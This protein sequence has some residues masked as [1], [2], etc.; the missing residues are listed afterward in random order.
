[1][2]NLSSALKWLIIKKEEKFLFFFSLFLFL[3]IYGG[4]FLRMG[5]S[6]DET[7]DAYGDATGTYVAAGRWG[8]AL[9]RT[10]MGKGCMPWAYGMVSACAISLA[11]IYQIRLFEISC[12]AIRYIY[13]MASLGCTQ[14]LYMLPYSF[15]ADCVAVSL[16][17]ATIACGILYHLPRTR[18]SLLVTVLLFT[19]AISTY[20]TVAV[21]AAVLLLACHLTFLEKRPDK[22]YARNLVL[23]FLP[24]LVGIGLWYLLSR[25]SLLLPWV[26]INDIHYMRAVQADIV[27]WDVLL[28]EYNRGSCGKLFWYIMAMPRTLLGFTYPGGWVYATALAPLAFLI[29]KERRKGRISL[30][31]VRLFSLLLIWVSP[32]ALTLIMGMSHPSVR[33]ELSQPLALAFLWTYALRNHPSCRCLLYVLLAC[34]A[35][36]SIRASYDVSHYAWNERLK[37]VD[38]ESLKQYIQEKRSVTPL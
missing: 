26:N 27:G 21:Y 6:Y 11:I 34:F 33:A 20:Q 7:I 17:L 31:F 10:L 35:F 30:H 1:M 14:F 36:I 24:L 13:V 19:L 8:I 23:S 9:Y 12:K 18:I 38:T 28:S 32:C 22:T 15:Q 5:V 2:E 25:I 4:M 37:E 29:F 3:F 16:L